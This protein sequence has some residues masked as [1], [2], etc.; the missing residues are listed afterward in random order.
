MTHEKV[1][2]EDKGNKGMKK[3]MTFDEIKEYIKDK[4]NYSDVWD[5]FEEEG[6]I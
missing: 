3:E 4:P 6:W 5:A 2:M 1:Y